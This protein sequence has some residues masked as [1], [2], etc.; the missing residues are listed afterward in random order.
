MINFGGV[1]VAFIEASIMVAL[2]RRIKLI[3][4]S[5]FNAVTFPLLV[6]CSVGGRL[7]C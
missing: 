7:V 6:A 4:T 1:H 5:I 3:V 2:K